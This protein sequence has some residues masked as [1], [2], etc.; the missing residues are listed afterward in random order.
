MDGMPKTEEGMQSKDKNMMCYCQSISNT[1]RW[2]AVNIWRKR[3]YVGLLVSYGG[4]PYVPP[5]KI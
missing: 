3:Q 1:L 4:Q 5:S 2:L